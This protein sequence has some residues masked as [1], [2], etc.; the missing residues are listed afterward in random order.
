VRE[1]VHK[2]FW[3]GNLREVDNLEYLGI[4]G[5]IILKHIFKK[6][7][8]E[9]WTGFIWL[10]NEQL[11]GFCECGNEHSLFIKYGKSVV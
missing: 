11:M 10:G 3:W 2:R 8:G 9:T 5:R 6:R 7:N 1:A 4:D